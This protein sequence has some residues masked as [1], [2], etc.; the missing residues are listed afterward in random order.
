MILWPS[1]TTLPHPSLDFGNKIASS[2]LRLVA[3]RQLVGKKGL[4]G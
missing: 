1:P 4:S 3:G 2:A